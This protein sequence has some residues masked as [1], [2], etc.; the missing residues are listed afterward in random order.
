MTFNKLIIVEGR[1]DKLKIAPILAEDIPIICTN[2]TVSASRLEEILAPYEDFEMYAF[3]DAD[4]SGDKLRALFKREFPDAYHLHTSPSYKQVEAT[5]R[6]H[7]ARILLAADIKV[8]KEYLI[9]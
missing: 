7:L 6:R 2:G 5:P 4:A 1:Q 8:H 3:F 9:V